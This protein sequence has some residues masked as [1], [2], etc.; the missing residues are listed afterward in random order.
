MVFG[1]FLYKENKNFTLSKPVCEGCY[2]Y[3]IIGFIDRERFL[4]EA[5]YVGS[6][7]LVLSLFD[8]HQANRGLL[9]SMSTNEVRDK[10]S[11]QLLESAN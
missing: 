8:A 7:R 3:F 4:I 5:R 9:V 1:S 10:L 2:K 11:A 6:E